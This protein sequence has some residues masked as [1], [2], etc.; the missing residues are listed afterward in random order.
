MW[1]VLCC[2]VW[3]S[4]MR[5]RVEETRRKT[6]SSFFSSVVR[7][8]RPRP[9]INLTAFWHGAL[10]DRW[11]SLSLSLS[12]QQRL[13]Q[14]RRRRRKTLARREKRRERIRQCHAADLEEPSLLACCWPAAALCTP[15]RSLALGKEKKKK[16]KKKK[17]TLHA[18]QIDTDTRHSSEILLLLSHFKETTKTQ[19]GPT[20]ILPARIIQRPWAVTQ[21]WT[22]PHSIESISYCRCYDAIPILISDA[23]LIGSIDHLVHSKWFPYYLST[24]NE[25]MF[26][27]IRP[28]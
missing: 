26:F 14:R 12:R 22:Q 27:K 19:C 23:E 2:A 7:P 28:Q 16:K 8:R 4:E 6:S 17:K 20:F 5:R 25:S 9:T 21:W 1:A 24:K 15:E 13:L 3:C 18:Q 10:R 11:V